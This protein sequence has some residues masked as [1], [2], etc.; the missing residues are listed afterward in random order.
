M[1]NLEY[2]M[3]LNN[4]YYINPNSIH[5]RFPMKIKNATTKDTGID[6]DLIRVNNFLHN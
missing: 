2:Q 6:F 5:I 1:E 4:S 3:L